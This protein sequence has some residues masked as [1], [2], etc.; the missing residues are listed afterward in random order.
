MV[1]GIYK[2]VFD[3]ISEDLGFNIKELW[4]EKL[5]TPE[6]IKKAG[7]FLLKAAIS[8]ILP[9]ML[10]LVTF[11]NILSDEH[12]IDLNPNSSK[13]EEYIN[14]S[15]F[16]SQI[17]QFQENLTAS[18]AL[19]KANAKHICESFVSNETK[20]IKFGDLIKIVKKNGTADKLIYNGIMTDKYLNDN[21]GAIFNMTKELNPNCQLPDIQDGENINTTMKLTEMQVQH[22]IKE[23]KKQLKQHDL[24]NQP[25]VYFSSKNIK[26][27]ESLKTHLR[28]KYKNAV[29][30]KIKTLNQEQTQHYRNKLSIFNEITGFYQY[31]ATEILS[32]KIEDLKE[33]T[34]REKLITLITNIHTRDKSSYDKIVSSDK[35][36]EF[37]TKDPDYQHTSFFS[38]VDKGY[39]TNL[40]KGLLN[41]VFKS[42]L[43]ELF[44]NIEGSPELTTRIKAKKMLDIFNNSTLMYQVWVKRKIQKD[45]LIDL[46][47]SLCRGI[48][49]LQDEARENINVMKEKIVLER[50]GNNLYKDNNPVTKMYS[51]WYRT[52]D[53]MKGITKN[54]IC[55]NFTSQ[56]YNL[57]TPNTFTDYILGN[58]SKFT[59]YVGLGPVPNTNQLYSWFSKQLAQYFASD[60]VMGLLNEIKSYIDLLFLG[61]FSQVYGLFGEM[62]TKI[63]QGLRH[64]IPKSKT[65]DDIAED[66]DDDGT[67]NSSDTQQESDPFRAQSKDILNEAR[68]Q[69]N[70]ANKNN[71]HL[72]NLAAK[73]SI[74]GS[75]LKKGSQKISLAST[76]E[77]LGDT[78]QL[79]GVFTLKSSL[80]YTFDLVLRSV[81]HYLGASGLVIMGTF[82]AFTCCFQYL[83][84]N[85]SV[86]DGDKKNPVFEKLRYLFFGGSFIY[87]LAA[88]PLVYAG[89][90]PVYHIVRVVTTFTFGL[91]LLGT[92]KQIMKNF[93]D[94]TSVS[95][96]VLY[97]HHSLLNSN[98]WFDLEYVSKIVEYIPD[99][100][101]AGLINA[102]YNGD[103]YAF[104][105]AL[106][107]NI[108][109][110]AQLSA[111]A[112]DML[113]FMKVFAEAFQ[114]KEKDNTAQYYEYIY[115]NTAWE[116]SQ[117][118]TSIQDARYG[119]TLDEISK[120]I[121]KDKI[122]E[123]LSKMDK[124][125]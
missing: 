17:K 106:Y 38:E 95:N 76:T 5:N 44:P 108:C 30:E 52:T 94:C 16:N 57:C 31:L 12:K 89:I 8:I 77:F 56:I 6:K 4:T 116:K 53:T 14:S 34:I 48:V 43:D 87:F 113:L 15:I 39:G 90:Y 37:L 7:V 22:D 59:P 99:L 84:H 80:I 118:P 58:V 47:N 72:K 101:G 70:G 74:M 71:V 25:K 121:K 123:D 98:S 112:A 73:C 36:L 115:S 26:E 103:I 120:N 50:I 27:L 69:M 13:M 105:R 124:E 93:R 81:P 92:S 35:K 51:A 82:L 104:S 85:N 18:E 64:L 1:N 88:V 28:L 125:D 96:I 86:E 61:R 32:E 40:I 42:Y 33:N 3:Q 119:I 75:I 66:V 62:F 100:A 122:M 97:T 20:Q 79:F 10:G 49:D 21:T 41:K 68:K 111:I 67:D 55:S 78:L 46:M 11:G 102:I 107:I 83:L 19:Y 2:R 63:G 29:D 110:M 9:W 60:R 24:R 54:I 109:H 91:S 45:G 65:T 117:V 114:A 23:L